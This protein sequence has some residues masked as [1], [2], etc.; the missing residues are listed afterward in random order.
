M[1][2]AEKEMSTEVLHYLEKEFKK[3]NKD[4]RIDK[5]TKISK[6]NFMINLLKFIENYDKNIAILNE[7][8]YK[9]KWQYNER[10]DNHN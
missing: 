2:K 1:N 9:D 8:C 7:E 3:V 5:D 6:M 10:G 4:R